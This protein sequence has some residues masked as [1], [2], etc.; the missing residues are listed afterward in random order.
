MKLNESVISMAVCLALAMSSYCTACVFCEP[1]GEGGWCDKPED[2]TCVKCTT[3]A[4][5]TAPPCP[6]D[7]D[8]GYGSDPIQCF[9]G[10]PDLYDDC[11]GKRD[12]TGAWVFV[13]CYTHYTCEEGSVQAG[14]CCSPITK[15]CFT[16]LLCIVLGCRECTYYDSTAY[17]QRVEECFNN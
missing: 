7:V 9:M 6:D 5:G 11:R 1:E 2:A 13:D 10:P 12:E 17:T 3:G 15:K 16:G 14:H 8:L 4:F